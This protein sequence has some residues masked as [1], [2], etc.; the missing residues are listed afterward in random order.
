MVVHV[1]PMEYADVVTVL[2]AHS[3]TTRVQEGPMV[4][5]ARRLVSVPPQPSVYLI[6]GSVCA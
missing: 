6:Q 2:S 3:V 4:G 1:S 5:T